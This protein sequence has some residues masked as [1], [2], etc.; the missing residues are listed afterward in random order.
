M[1]VV[2]RTDYPKFTDYRRYKQHVREDFQYRCAYCRLH[3]SAYGLR[4]SMS[5]DHFRPKALF[6]NLITEYSNLYYCCGPCNDRKS[7]HWPDATQQ[8]RG[9][10]FVDVCRDEWDDHLE[11]IQDVIAAKTRAG[12]YT[13]E[14][15]K[16]D[17]PGLVRRIRNLRF[18]IE[19]AERELS[20]IDRIRQRD[21]SFLSADTLR[22]L[23]EQE[24]V[25]RNQLEELQQPA[26]L[27]E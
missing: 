7:D 3:E 11:V 1:K 23:A 4:R 18:A 21:G 16:F 2:H 27:L 14:K 24:T 26:P 10:R 9:M 12:Q 17:R 19:Q 15:L 22:D 25:F 8:K 5:I 6:G 13:S 20:R